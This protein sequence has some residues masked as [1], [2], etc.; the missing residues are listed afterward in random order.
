MDEKLVNAIVEKIELFKQELVAI[1][2]D[3]DTLNHFIVKWIVEGDNFYFQNIYNETNYVKSINDSYS[4]IKLKFEVAKQLSIPHTNVI[5]MGSSKHGFSLKP[6]KDKDDNEEYKFKNFDNINSDIDL[7]IIDNQL[8]DLELESINRYTKYYNKVQIQ[9]FFIPEKNSYDDFSR[10]VL[11]GVIKPE[12]LPKSYNWSSK[13]DCISSM[14]GRKFN[15]KVTIA[16]FKSWDYFMIY[17]RQNI[18]KI[19]QYLKIKESAC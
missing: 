5:I 19:H 10:D 2:N 9:S 3:D 12:L 18:K 7:T 16:L 17:N 1:K 6:S 14:Y 15:K 11:R 4:E 8:F 13:F